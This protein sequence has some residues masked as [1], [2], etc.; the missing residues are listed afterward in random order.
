M[1][2]IATT[3]STG[4]AEHGLQAFACAETSKWSMPKILANQVF[5]LAL[6]VTVSAFGFV[7]ALQPMPVSAFDV[8]DVVYVK[9]RPERF[10]GV[11]AV[12]Y[13]V[14]VAMAVAA[15]GRSWAPASAAAS[16]ALWS[17]RFA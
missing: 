7:A 15:V 5:V 9:V 13:E 11:F 14:A 2:S 17:C 16:V 4:L 12:A 3:T 1:R 10:A 8:H 6:P